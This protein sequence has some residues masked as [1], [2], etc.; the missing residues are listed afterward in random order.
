M[1]PRPF[2]I[3]DVSNEIAPTCHSK[4]VQ[5][6]LAV[7]N[8]PCCA[9]RPK[10]GI[11]QNWVSF[12]LGERDDRS[13]GRTVGE[14]LRNKTPRRS[15][16]EPSRDF[17]WSG[18]RRASEQPRKRGGGRESE[19]LPSTNRNQQDEFHH[20]HRASAP[21]LLFLPC[22]LNCMIRN[23]SESVRTFLLGGNRECG[24]GEKFFFC[25][26]FRSDG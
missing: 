7:T 23:F 21:P 9:E 3:S 25:F 12:P 1:N 13:D 24:C 6:C 15:E 20:T 26:F 11:R 10:I 17:H 4:G 19:T 5:S 2:E 16:Y 14:N 8:L 22:A 18:Q